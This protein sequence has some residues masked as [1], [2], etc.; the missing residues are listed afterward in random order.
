M[1]EIKLIFFDNCDTCNQ[2][3]PHYEFIAGHKNMCIDCYCKLTNKKRL[4]VVNSIKNF[5]KRIDDLGGTVIGEYKG[6]GIQIKCICKN[7][8][9][10]NPTPDN[11]KQGVSMCNECPRNSSKIAEQNFR[12]II[13][14]RGG[15][16]IGKYINNKTR[17][18]CR[19]KNGHICNPTPH[20]IKR[21]YNMCK[22]CIREIGEQN[23]HYN[24][25]KLGGTVIGKYI[26]NNTRVKCRCKNGHHCSPTPESIHR[27]QGMCGPCAGNDS[28][29]AEMNFH[30][31]IQDQGGTVIGKYTNN[32]TPVECRC[33]DDHICN[34]T[35]NSIQQ[36]G[37]MCA[38]CAGND[39]ETAKQNFHKNIHDRG[40]TVIG[41][42]TNNRTSVECICKRGHYCKSN[43][44]SVQQG[45]AMCRRCSK[46]KGY[47][48]KA[49]S[50]MNSISNT[51]QHAENGGEF[52]IP[53]IGRVDGID[54]ETNTVYEY[55]GCFWHGCIKCF[56]SDYMNPINYK[57]ASELYNKTIERSLAIR[58]A[59]Y[60]LIEM[61]E[62]D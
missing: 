8:H 48:K 49:I 24:I 33:K 44:D 26:N 7:D 58:N 46:S 1:K 4:D 30:K 25:E 35:P 12:D 5:Y 52:K 16:V 34:P 3:Y 57:T 47:S 36:G 9:I 53:N 29:T 60:N 38:I 20:Y 40:G 50:W 43:P 59:G 45:H 27:G 2:E 28:K 51:I 37:G 54:H 18:K 14:D 23:F 61:W 41:K 21:G 22:E 11:I 19:C 10:C 55:Y 17:V 39:F 6:S 32:S 13:H 31:N 62:C 15:T 56:K 42:Y